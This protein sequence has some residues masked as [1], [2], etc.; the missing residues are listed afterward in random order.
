MDPDKPENILDVG[1]RLFHVLPL[2]GVNYRAAPLV[3]RLDYVLLVI[4]DIVVRIELRL[5]RD[6]PG[7]RISALSPAGSADE[8]LRAITLDEF[9]DYFE[10]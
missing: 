3:A 9:L 8:R 10:F 5:A 6:N 1:G 2:A 7:V 4:R